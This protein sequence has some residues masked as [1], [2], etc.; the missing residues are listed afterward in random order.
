MTTLQATFEATCASRW[1]GCRSEELH[2]TIAQRI[3]A[4]LG[5]DLPLSQL[6][7]A[8]IYSR[9]VLPW[10]RQRLARTTINRRRSVFMAMM[11]EAQRL[12]WLTTRPEWSKE[13]M[14]TID[15]KLEGQNDRWLTEDEVRDVII[16]MVLRAVPTVYLRLTRFLLDTGLRIGEALSL[17]WRDVDTQNAVVYVRSS[18]SGKPRTVPLTESAEISLRIQRAHKLDK[19]WADANRHTYGK[20]LRSLPISGVTPHVLRHTFATRLVQRGFAIEKLSRLLGH[21]DISM[22]MRYAHHR[23]Q[24]LDEARNLLEGS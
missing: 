15:G 8:L 7:S 18:K 24:E 20:L 3:L 1:D 21:A 5:P 9:L 19:P 16:S 17:E 4:A 12:G 10:K 2:C 11:S 13:S 14:R 22:T 23:P 6:S